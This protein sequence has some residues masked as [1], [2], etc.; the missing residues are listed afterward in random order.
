VRPEESVGW[1]ERGVAR[2]RP[3]RS[4]PQRAAGRWAAMEQGSQA[5]NGGGD[6]RGEGVCG[7]SE[8]AR[9]ESAPPTLLQRPERIGSTISPTKEPAM[10]LS[11]VLLPVL[12]LGGAV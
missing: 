10:A 7:V 8:P 1:G 4:L 2:R 11:R 9:F 5:R 12:A 6:S 3:R